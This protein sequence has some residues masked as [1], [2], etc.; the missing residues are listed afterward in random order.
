[1]SRKCLRL[2]QRV[3]PRAVDGCTDGRRRLAAALPAAALAP[4]GDVRTQEEEQSL[5]S[6]WEVS[7]KCLGS[8]REVSGK[9]GKCL[10]SLGSVS[11]V[12]R[13]CLGSV[14]EVS[15][16]CLGSVWEVSGKCLGSV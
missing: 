1:M 11:E 4:L 9:C 13:K 2:A 16:K 5:G 15:R 8:V 10:G 6:V 14:H 12:S 7:G 3:Q